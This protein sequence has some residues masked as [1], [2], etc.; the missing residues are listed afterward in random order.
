MGDNVPDGKRHTR[1]DEVIVF[2]DKKRDQFLKKPE[3]QVYAHL[4]GY[5]NR[6]CLFRSLKMGN[7]T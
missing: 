2:L 3:N 6:E 5:Q 7:K 1:Q 4:I